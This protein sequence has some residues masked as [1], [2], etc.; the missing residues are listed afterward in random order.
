MFKTR[1]ASPATLRGQ[2]FSFRIAN[3]A[4]TVRELP[5]K[6]KLLNWG[7]NETVKGPIVVG[8]RTLAQLA[9]NQKRLGYDRVQIDFNHQTVPGSETYQADPVEVAGYG[10]PVVIPHDGLYLI[11]IEWTPAGKKY[12]A[13]YHDLSPT[14]K[15]DG[16]GEVIFL[17]SVALC[18]QGA[19]KDLTFYNTSFLQPQASPQSMENP[20]PPAA[21]QGE[22]VDYRGLLVALLQKLGINIPDTATDADI[23]TMVDQF[24]APASPGENAD[25]DGAG[26][27]VHSLGVEARIDQIEKDSL[28]TLAATQGKV[29]PLS[30]EEIRSTPVTVLRSMI[31]R[32][33]TGT[34]PLASRKSGSP[35]KSNEPGRVTTLT[36]AQKL[37]VKNLNLSEEKYLATLNAE[38]TASTILL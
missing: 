20:T 36:A 21:P 15:L 3:G 34:V 38:K 19:V 24:K 18:R 5:T 32:L 2:L 4:P 8:T 16:H 1:S 30:T 35:A 22:T 7:V 9:A 14:P 13:N 11:D 12:A 28:L 26:A 25:E 23:A 31:D 37:I 29:I 10:T 33:P 17:H 6:L 27:S